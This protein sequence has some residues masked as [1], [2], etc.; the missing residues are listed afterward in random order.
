MAGCTGNNALDTSMSEPSSLE[1]GGRD[2]HPVGAR[3]C[4]LWERKQTFCGSHINQFLWQNLK[5]M[6]ANK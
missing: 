4:V 5:N 2:K 1:A 6:C 3:V